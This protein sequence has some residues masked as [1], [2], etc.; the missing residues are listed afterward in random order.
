MLTH[1]T[2][3][4]S[5]MKYLLISFVALVFSSCS[6][7]ATY[8]P[9]EIDTAVSFSNSSYEPVPTILVTTIEYAH[10]HYGGIESVVYNLPKGMSSETYDIVTSRV[11]KSKPL[12]NAGEQAY[13]ITELRVRGLKAEADIVFPRAGGGNETATLYLSK[14]FTNPWRVNRER[15][16]LI[17]VAQAP[18]PNYVAPEHTAIVDTE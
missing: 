12:E 3:Y 15:I 9:I 6:P 18:A 14:S 13:H 10:D 8:P 1:C 2:C 5:L 17:P 4:T 7:V 16:W 11:A